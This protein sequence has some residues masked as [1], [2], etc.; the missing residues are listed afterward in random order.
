MGREQGSFLAGKLRQLG[1]SVAILGPSQETMAVGE[2][3]L[4]SLVGS[5]VEKAGVQPGGTHRIFVQSGNS[6][7]GDTISDT[8]NIEVG[9]DGKISVGQIERVEINEWAK[10]YRSLGLLRGR[11]RLAVINHKIKEL[12]EHQS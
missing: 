5:D 3:Q 6:L 10:T 4:L 9:V 12:T 1:E 11:A 8:I 2:Q 7:F